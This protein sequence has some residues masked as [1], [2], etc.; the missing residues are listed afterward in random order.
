MCRSE[1]AS[2]KDELRSVAKID[3]IKLGM[4]TDV[5]EMLEVYDCDLATWEMA[6]FVIDYEKWGKSIV[7]TQDSIDESVQGKTLVFVSK[8]SFKIE[9][10]IRTD[11]I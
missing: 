7:L 2:G 9:N 8:E 1:I 4:H 11:I 3:E 6:K 5:R 10:F